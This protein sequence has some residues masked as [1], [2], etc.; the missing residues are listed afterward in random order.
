MTLQCHRIVQQ[1]LK[2]CSSS[3]QASG[4]NMPVTLPPLPLNKG[5]AFCCRDSSLTSSGFKCSV[6]A[7]QLTALTSDSV[8]RDNRCSLVSVRCLRPEQ[9]PLGVSVLSWPNGVWNAAQTPENNDGVAAPSTDYGLKLPVGHEGLGVGD[10]KLGSE[11][12]ERTRTI[13]KGLGK[14][15]LSPKEQFSLSVSSMF[16]SLIHTDFNYVPC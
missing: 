2:I 6:S 3:F 9:P 1:F 15:S 5:A 16:Y 10:N 12:T 4:Q 14:L 8:N 7:V 13:P 11:G